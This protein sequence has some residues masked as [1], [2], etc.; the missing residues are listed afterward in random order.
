MA[1]KLAYR[2]SEPTKFKKT[3]IK[4][5]DEVLVIAGKEKGKKGKVLA[6]DKRK[7][8]VYIEGVNKRRRYVRPTQENP[9]GGAIEI[10]FPIHLSN[11]MFSDPKADN[12]AKPKKKI[13]AV[14]LG[15]LKKDGKTL[16]ITRPE[17]KEV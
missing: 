12:K 14:R 16:R 7:D 2:G 9:Q 17:G 6:I 15:F 5:D 11:V 4:K 3:K 13:K 1:T 8:R 10:E